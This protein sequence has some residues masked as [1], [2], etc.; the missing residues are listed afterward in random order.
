MEARACRLR[1][2][3]T[4]ITRWSIF[5]TVVATGVT[6]TCTGSRSMAAASWEISR[7]MVAEKNK[8]C[9]SAG[10]VETMRRMG[11]MKPRSSMWSASSSTRISTPSSVTARSCMWSSRRPGVAT[12]TS[13][14]F[15]TAR[16]WRGFGTP[17]NIRAVRNPV[18][19]V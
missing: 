12:S 13:M 6:A 8:V 19:P 5:S 15:C 11:T 17:P 18:R 7:G 9:R 16:A 3:S 1:D 10:M 4:N 2:A 14:P